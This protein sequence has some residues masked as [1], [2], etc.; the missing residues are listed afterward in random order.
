MCSSRSRAAARRSMPGSRSRGTIIVTT[1]DDVRV[2]PEWLTRPA[3]RSSPSIATTSAARCCRSGGAAAGVD[4]E[5]RRQ[6]VGG[7]RAARLRDGPFPSSRRR[8]GSRSASTWRSGARRSTAPACGTTGSAAG[9]ARSSDRKC[10]SGCPGPRR[11]TARLLRAVDGRPARH[12]ARSPEQALLPALG[13]LERHQP[14]PDVPQRL[15]RHAGAREHG[16]RFLARAAHPRRAAVLRQG[17]REIKRGILSAWRGDAVAS[18]E[19]ELWL[20]F[21]AASL[22]SGWKIA[23]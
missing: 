22:R 1:D 17:P 14:R 8:T 9:R 2:E 18:F 3:R 6:A 20:W 19:S 12:P 15:D 5:S 23:V 10:G 11:G 7:D 21:F 13:P 16:A 4:P